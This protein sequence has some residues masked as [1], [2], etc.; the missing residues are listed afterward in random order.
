MHSEGPGSHFRFEPEV[1]A[2]LLGG[3]EEDSLEKI[4]PEVADHYAV[5][6]CF[7]HAHGAIR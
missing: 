5:E 7:R 6:Q 4:E 1:F 2:K 3:A